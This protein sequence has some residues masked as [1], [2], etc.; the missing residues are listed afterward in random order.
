MVMVPMRVNDIRIRL[1]KLV[2]RIFTE[3]FRSRYAEA[4][5]SYEPEAEKH[6]LRCLPQC[7]EY[8]RQVA[9][10]LSKPE[11]IERL[12]DTL[13]TSVVF[14]VGLRYHLLTCSLIEKDQDEEMN[15]P[16]DDI[17]FFKH[18][19]IYYCEESA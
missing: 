16:K 2:E 10:Y 6:L 5:P 17:S 12:N 4:V 11:E 18:M 19:L 14:C 15:V 1:G 7:D 8:L 3:S 13:D 9:G